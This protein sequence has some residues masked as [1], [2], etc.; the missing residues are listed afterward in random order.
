MREVRD[1]EQGVRVL[2][3]EDE[4]GDAEI[5]KSV[6][7]SEGIPCEAVRVESRD[8]FEEALS[9]GGFDLIF[10]D[11]SLPSF[12]GIAA[13]RMAREKAPGVPFI[14]VSGT[15]GEELA[16]DMLKGGATDYV[17]KQ[18]LSR[19]APAVR[20][21]LQEA[22]ADSGRRRAEAA[23]S[24]RHELERIVA[25]LSADFINIRAEHMAEGIG[26][27]LKAVG[28]LAGADL[29]R[30]CLVSE[31]GA[32][33]EVAGQWRS[34]G[35]GPEGPGAPAARACPWMARLCEFEPVQIGRASD[36][37]E[38][39]ERSY[40]LEEGMSSAVVVP[41][42]CGNSL[43]G[44][45][46]FFS[47]AEKA[48]CRE[49]VSMFKVL[50]EIF[51]SALERR[52]AE[53]RIKRQLEQMQALRTIDMAINASLDLRVTL[54]VFLDQVVSRLRVDAACVLLLDRHS[55][56]L[57]YAAGRGFRTD[58]A[59]RLE[60]R[61]GEGMAGKA[62]YE[63]APLAVHELSGPAGEPYAALM[64]REGIRAYFGV[65]LISKGSVKG[66]LETYRREPFSPTPDWLNFL[67]AL[68]GQ[69]AI[70]IDNASLFNDLQ[71]MNSELAMAYDAT[72]QGWSAALDYR[73]R[74]T[75]GHSQRVTEMTLRMATV[76]DVPEA[77]L[78]HIRRG[79]LLHDIGKLGVPDS[80]LFKDGE[81][82]GEEW[83]VMKKH[84]EI[85]LGLL[86]PISF[87]RPALDIPYAHHER[88][89]G[90]GYPRGLKGG[91]IPL[92]ARVF[93]VVDVW[94]ALRSVR[95]YRPAWPDERVR[96]YI[97][98]QAGAGFDP[99]V[100]DVFLEVMQWS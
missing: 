62:A 97:R 59:K 16:I 99:E 6:L 32:R 64:E 50:A 5:V 3:L 87:L 60:M 82:N 25:A 7:A 47:L 86:S 75:E 92:A 29:A 88:W 56:M 21:A 71:R 89:D 1:L 42:V 27:A 35:A 66:V 20:R 94:D 14:F 49:D 73:D 52:K 51:V 40:L 48:W 69:A 63:R 46:G 81:L 90:S 53:G 10:A 13:L 83:G 15:M 93:S 17:L 72:I 67:E 76:M 45:V 96:D 57:K 43:K 98:G 24:Y 91:H 78:V 100:V 23:L 70:A 11:Y 38:G 65:P 28:E 61:L 80:I 54:D 4:P 84:P 33:M 8:G 74:E 77:D 95:S 31:D 44:F 68:A 2:H 37:P 58:L 39:E 85:A 55:F 9:R 79:A 26:R 30:V 22:R 18:R 19:L 12:D 36:L 34:M 41:M